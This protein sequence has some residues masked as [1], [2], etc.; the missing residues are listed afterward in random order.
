MAK[1]PFRYLYR[2]Y[3]ELGPIFRLR[4]VKRRF[5][6]LAGL[7]ANQL[8]AQQSNELFRSKEFWEGFGQTINA[9]EFL[10]SID[11]EPHRRVRK[12]MQPGFSQ[13][14]T[15]SR[16]PAFVSLT[17]EIASRVEGQERVPVVRLMQRV[18]TQQL[19]VLLC[20]VRT[21][22]YF[23]DLRVFINTLLNVTVIHRWPRLMLHRPRYRRARRRAY[24]FARQ[25]IATHKSTSREQA[26][27]I[28]DLLAAYDAGE[29]YQTEAELQ[30]AAMG[31]F[32]AGMDTVSNTM[33]FMLYA[34][35]TH[36]DALDRVRMDASALL[37]SGPTIEKLKACHAL[38]GA[39]RETLRLYPVVPALL[40]AAARPF[41]FKGYRVD[42]GD[43]VLFALA[44]PHYMPALYE[45]PA[46][47]DIDRFGPKQHRHRSAGSF[48]PFGLGP[49]GCLGSSLG[50]LMIALT[51]ASLVHD[52]RIEMAPP[53]YQLRVGVDPTPTP[54]NFFI[55]LFRN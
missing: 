31:P 41:E 47:F 45:N 18:A 28:D 14:T 21:D 39:V 9:T 30:I 17:R 5:T 12:V 22:S 27:I 6:V 10:M 55:R 13:G 48:A 49:H 29:I 23:E 1:D 19:G 46:A 51:L 44:V 33:A 2:R 25:V 43:L 53:D 40:R 50:E 42:E 8:F 3:L 4:L 35:L 34:L 26:D 38:L 36:P 24:E 11:G 37:G 15:L 32:L 20:D 52:Y 7:E 16:L 54:A